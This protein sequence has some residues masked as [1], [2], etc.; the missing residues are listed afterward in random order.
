MRWRLEGPGLKGLKFRWTLLRMF[1]GIERGVG[2]FG[3]WGV[4]LPPSLRV[5]LTSP[6]TPSTLISQTKHRGPSGA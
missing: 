3:E 1:L 4:S 5:S 2:G 6:Y